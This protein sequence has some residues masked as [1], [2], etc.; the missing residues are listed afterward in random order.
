ML[1]PGPCSATNGGTS[2]PTN[3]RGSSGL[4]RKAGSLWGLIFPGRRL[5]RS[6]D[7]AGLPAAEILITWPQLEHRPRLPCECSST[8]NC[9]P[10]FSQVKLMNIPPSVAPPYRQ[11]C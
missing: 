3:G 6:F 8:E 10:Q 11:P 4:S 9:F 1:Q 5:S 2:G 7:Q